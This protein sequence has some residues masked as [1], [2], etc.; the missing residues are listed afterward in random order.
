MVGCLWIDRLSA[1]SSPAERLF[2]EDSSAESLL[3]D[4]YPSHCLS[5]E[6]PSA[7]FLLLLRGAKMLPAAAT[8]S[9]FPWAHPGSGP[10][11]SPAADKTA[12][13]NHSEHNLPPARP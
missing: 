11:A 12:L 9:P 13:Y 7:G 2:V 3:F 5:A 8:R 6:F 1:R 4:R 10:I